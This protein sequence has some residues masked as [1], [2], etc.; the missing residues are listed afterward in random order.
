VEKIMKSRC[1]GI[2]GARVGQ[3]MVGYVGETIYED[4]AKKD[5]GYHD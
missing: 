2:G 3:D 4:D 1:V 5:R